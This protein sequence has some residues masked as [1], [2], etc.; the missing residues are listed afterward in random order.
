MVTGFNSEFTF[1]NRVYH[2]QTENRGPSNPVI[3]TLIYVKGEIL[4]SIKQDYHDLL[5][6][7]PLDYDQI[8]Q[9]MEDQHRQV[10]H[11]IKSGKYD[12]TPNDPLFDEQRVF[13]NRPLEE[14]IVEYLEGE[15]WVETLELAMQQPLSP[16]F[17]SMLQLSV[18][19]RLCPSRA[20]VPGADV[21]VKF[22]SGMKKTYVLRTGRTDRQGV[23]TTTLDL[24]PT[25]PGRCAIQ[26]SCVSEHGMDE[27]SAP[28]TK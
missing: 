25:Q 15:G 10:L 16:K 28:I 26:V 18:Q 7:P 5:D 3:Q 1:L 9:R 12:F 24:P 2:V 14:A 23:F 4:D 11:D 19:A 6:S 13:N 17:D 8:M 20:P 27:I 22:I 21:S